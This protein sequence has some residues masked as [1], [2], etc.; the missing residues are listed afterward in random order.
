MEQRVLR[1][2]HLEEQQEM[3]GSQV[4]YRLSQLKFVQ[5]AHALQVGA[6]R[7]KLRQLLQQKFANSKGLGWGS[8]SSKW[9]L[10]SMTTPLFSPR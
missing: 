10:S 4:S 7:T 1:F 2:N 9:R 3:L 5:Q 6:T 8:C